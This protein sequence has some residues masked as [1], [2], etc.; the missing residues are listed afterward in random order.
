MDKFTK[1]GNRIRDAWITHLKGDL[2]SESENTASL[3]IKVSDNWV[4]YEKEKP[5]KGGYYLCKIWEVSI[6]QYGNFRKFEVCYFH[7]DEK[8]FSGY[9][10][11]F[12]YKNKLSHYSKVIWWKEINNAP[13]NEN[14]YKIPKYKL[15]EDQ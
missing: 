7:S 11:V 3:P 5:D 10:K 4:D 1:F 12:F 15:T 2:G 9:P 6:N 14:H 13:V 8:I